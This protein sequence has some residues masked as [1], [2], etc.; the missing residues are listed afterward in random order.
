LIDPPTFSQSKEFGVFRVEKDF[1]KLIEKALP[2]LKP[3]GVLFCSSNASGWRPED[4]LS[5]IRAAIA[6]SRRKIEREK[7]FP[8]PPD[9]PISRKEPSYLKTVWLQLE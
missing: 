5:Q 3:N 6:K 8:Q 1:W 7:Y 9:Y 2:L 4:F